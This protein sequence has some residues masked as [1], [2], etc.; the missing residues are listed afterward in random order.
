[1]VSSRR[2][3]HSRPVLHIAAAII[4]RG[5]EIVLVRQGAPGE[6]PLWGLPGGV[7]EDGELVLEGLSR[8]VLEETG[9]EIA[10]PLR[11]AF[12]VQIDNRR[13]E[14]LHRSRGRGSGYLATIWTFEVDTW[15]GELAPAD[16]DGFVFEARF[17]PL[18]EAMERLAEVPW[19]GYTVR[20]LRGEVE[21][22]SLH[23]ERWHADGRIEVVGP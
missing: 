4:R 16:P 8:E 15:R 7:L 19:H 17:V 6:E 10:E 9:L 5:D 22:G 20:Y 21:P 3:L 23:V 12:V 2:V 18:A 11:L 1:L 13:P 14:Q